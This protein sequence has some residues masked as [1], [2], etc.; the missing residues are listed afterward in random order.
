MKTVY[1]RTDTD[2]TPYE[3]TLYT[4]HEVH[5]KERNDKYPRAYTTNPVAPVG[6]SL[7]DLRGILEMMLRSLHKPVLTEDDFPRAAHGPSDPERVI[8]DWKDRTPP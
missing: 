4:I 8:H 6:D 3:E 7:E 5:Y 1:P 2:G